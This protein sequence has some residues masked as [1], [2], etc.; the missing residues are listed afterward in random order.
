M[1]PGYTPHYLAPTTSIDGPYRETFGLLDTIGGLHD[2]G[3]F[4]WWAMDN[5]RFTGAW[6]YPEWIEMLEFYPDLSRCLFSVVPDCPMDATGTLKWFWRYERTVRDM[7]YPVALTSQ[8][9]MTPS[10]VP[11]DA[12][13]CLF[14][15]GDDAHKRG[16]EGRNLIVEAKMR[17]KHV[18]VG[19]VNSGKVIR[20]Y[21]WMA[22]SWD[23]TT[24]ARHPRQQHKS[25]GSAVLYARAKQAERKEEWS[26]YTWPSTWQPSLLLT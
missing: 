2:V 9:G 13:D 17:G 8:N 10:I 24:L 20:N 18:H 12:I 25:I 26:Y 16:P 6:T 14:I 3:P 19:R 21:F 7:G 1:K 22:D 11:W 15:A 23:G 5:G 4:P